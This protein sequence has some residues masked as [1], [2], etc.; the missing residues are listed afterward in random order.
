MYST[1][2]MQYL[3]GIN[4]NMTKAIRAEIVSHLYHRVQQYTSRPTPEEYKTVCR[5]LIKEFP[6]LV[7]TPEAPIVSREYNIYIT[8]DL[9]TRVLHFLYRLPGK[10]PSGGASKTG[11]EPKKGF[12]MTPKKKSVRIK[13][14]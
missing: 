5:A 7:E 10:R 14:K 2:V 8:D 12:L 13:S 1:K 3:N 9:Q 4:P 6:C 11:G